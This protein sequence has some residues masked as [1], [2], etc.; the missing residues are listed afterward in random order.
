MYRAGYTKIPFLFAAD[1]CRAYSK[2]MFVLHEPDKAALRTYLLKGGPG[3]RKYMR[4]QVADLPDSYRRSHCRHTIPPPDVLV[5]RVEGVLADFKGAVCAKSQDPLITEEVQ[6][7]HNLQV[8]LIEEGLLSG[9]LAL[10][11]ISGVSCCNLATG[12]ASKF[13][14]CQ[15]QD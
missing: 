14:V 15:E 7:V 4:A 11:S 1:F 8:Q 2:A 12:G 10:S 6:K 9:E 5:E 3:K 13:L